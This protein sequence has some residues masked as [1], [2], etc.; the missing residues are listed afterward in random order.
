MLYCWLI[1][2]ARDI[3]TGSCAAWAPNETVTGR[4]S[5]HTSQ[6]NNKEGTARNHTQYIITQPPSPSTVNSHN[7]DLNEFWRWKDLQGLF[8]VWSESY[9]LMLL[10][11]ECQWLLEATGGSPDVVHLIKYASQVFRWHFE[12]S[13]WGPKK[14]V[15]YHKNDF[16]EFFGDLRRRLEIKIGSIL[17]SSGIFLSNGHKN[18]FILW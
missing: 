7:P 18:T 4:A 9:F 11:Y 8:Y 14:Q 1:S 17:K 12:A 6:Y 3:Q 5:G 16:M 13:R 15:N 10:I 2:G